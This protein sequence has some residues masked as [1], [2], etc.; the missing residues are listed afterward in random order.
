M[1]SSKTA[2]YEAVKIYTAVAQL[3]VV[4][5]VLLFFMAFYYLERCDINTL[6]DESSVS[7]RFRFP[8][9]PVRRPRAMHLGR[10]NFLFPR[11]PMI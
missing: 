10:L 4:V 6:D 9:K 3:G 7:T 2:L 5:G 11:M 8:L 1:T